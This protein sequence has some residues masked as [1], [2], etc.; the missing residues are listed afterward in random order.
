[1]K[2]R[3][4]DHESKS[5]KRRHY[6]QNYFAIICAALLAGIISLIVWLHGR[7]AGKNQTPETEITNNAPPADNSNLP[8]VTEQPLDEDGQSVWTSTDGVNFRAEPN[9]DSE[10]LTVLVTGTKLT[11]LG[12]ENGWVQ[13]EYNGQKDMSVQTML[14]IRNRIQQRRKQSKGKGKQ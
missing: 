6:C 1:M 9:T 11:L 7:N 12:E 14:P 8:P 13:A 4:N 10:I 5:Q 3:D 2:G